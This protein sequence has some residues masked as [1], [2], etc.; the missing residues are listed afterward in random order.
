MTL[1]D[2]LARDL[3]AVSVQLHDLMR[4]RA[5]LQDA[6]TRLRLGESEALVLTR[7]TMNARRRGQGVETLTSPAAT[8]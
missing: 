3:D 1:L 6:A 5:L 4:R 8:S 2:Q 7:L